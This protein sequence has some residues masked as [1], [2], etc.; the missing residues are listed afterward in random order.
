MGLMSSY[1][2]WGPSNEYG[3]GNMAD[4]WEIKD[5]SSLGPGGIVEVP[6]PSVT[7]SLERWQRIM[8]PLPTKAGI[9]EWRTGQRY[10]ADFEK[11]Q[12][13]YQHYQQYA[14][15]VPAAHGRIQGGPGPW[16][17]S[18][19]SGT[20]GTVPASQTVTGG[21]WTWKGVIESLIG[22]L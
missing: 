16:A 14:G 18:Q 21:T 20:G 17:P 8:R 4:L 12:Q 1:D 2:E 9:Y 5:L 3:V 15:R 11:L 7:V 22:K 19:I 6:D 13:Q 10:I